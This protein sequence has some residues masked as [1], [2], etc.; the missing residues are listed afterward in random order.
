MRSY[1]VYLTLNIIFSVVQLLD[2]KNNILQYVAE[3]EWWLLDYMIRLDLTTGSLGFA[4]W[5]DIRKCQT[6]VAD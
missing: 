1:L 2:R 4:P 5:L 6:H 3:C